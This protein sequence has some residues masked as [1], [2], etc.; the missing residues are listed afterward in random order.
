MNQSWMALDSM[1]THGFRASV[2]NQHPPVIFDEQELRTL[3]PLAWEAGRRGTWRC[4]KYG[5]K[6]LRKWND[7]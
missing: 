1:K 6:M 7:S 4:G 5:A 2:L 3:C